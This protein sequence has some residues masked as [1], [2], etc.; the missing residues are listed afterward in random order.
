MQIQQ[1]DLVHLVMAE[2][3]AAGGED[4]V[5]GFTQQVYP[6]GCVLD[7]MHPYPIN[8]PERMRDRF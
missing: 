2:D 7:G 8:I 6:A 3:L 5:T 1:V 4:S